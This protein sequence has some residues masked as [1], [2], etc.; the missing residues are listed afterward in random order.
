MKGDPGAG[1]ISLA[2]SVRLHRE[3]LQYVRAAAGSR[4][5]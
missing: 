3:V 1:Y 4:C 5:R 2:N